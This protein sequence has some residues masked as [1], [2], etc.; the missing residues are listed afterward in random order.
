M[1]EQADP[2]AAAW[3]WILQFLQT[4]KQRPGHF[5]G[6]ISFNEWNEE[7]KGEKAFVEFHNFSSAG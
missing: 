2:G 3:G 7:T 4:S 1:Q 5:R 6:N